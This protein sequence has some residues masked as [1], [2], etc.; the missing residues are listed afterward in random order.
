MLIIPGCRLPW[1]LF[2]H[3][4]IQE[5]E[6]FDS[7]PEETQQK[8]LLE[9][10]RTPEDFLQLYQSV[11]AKKVIRRSPYGGTTVGIWNGTRAKPPRN[12]IFFKNRPRKSKAKNLAHT[13]TIQSR[14]E[15]HAY[16]QSLGNF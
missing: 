1:R 5:R 3:E 4:N 2:L 7:L 9:S 10:I 13:H 12:G 6:L 14:N 15:M 16:V 11:G 8:L